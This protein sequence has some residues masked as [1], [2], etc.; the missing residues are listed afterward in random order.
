[1]AISRTVDHR[2]GMGA[3]RQ[4]RDSSALFLCPTASDNGFFF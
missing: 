2:A 1:M 4:P 3:D